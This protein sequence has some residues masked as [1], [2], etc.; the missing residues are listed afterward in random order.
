MSLNQVYY[1]SSTIGLE[2]GAGFRIHAATPGVPAD[3]LRQVEKL[4][5]YVPPR[6][7]PIDPTA[8]DLERFPLSLQFKALPGGIFVF[9]QAK[10]KGTDYSGRSGNYFVHLVT[11]SR[12]GQDV[13][14]KRNI[15]L[16][17][18]PVW[19]NS[20]IATT[21]L[22]ALDQVTPGHSVSPDHVDAFLRVAGGAE[23]LEAFLGAVL[24]ALRER[25]RILIVAEESDQVAGW[26]AVALYALPRSLA[27]PVSFNTYVSNPQN[28]DHLIVGAT[29]DCDFGFSPHEMQGQF[30]V[31]DFVG[32]RF[33]P[34]PVPSH[35]A[36]A[37]ARLVRDGLASVAEFGAFADSLPTPITLE[38]L[39]LAAQFFALRKTGSIAG[40]DP[41]PM[42]AWAEGRR[43]ALDAG[44]RDQLVTRVVDETVHD[45]DPK[46]IERL[47]QIIEND[48][49]SCERRWWP[50]AVTAV[51]ERTLVTCARE[52]PVERLDNWSRRLAKI[53]S[54]DAQDMQDRWW[55]GLRSVVDSPDRATV[56]LRLAN[57]AP[58]LGDH[59]ADLREVGARLIGPRLG[60]PDGDPSV[61]QVLS[62]SMRDQLLEGSLAAWRQQH[63]GVPGSELS[64]LLQD[65]ALRRVV[66]A[67]ALEAGD[68]DLLVPILVDETD[69][70]R[71]NT[72]RLEHVWGGLDEHQGRIPRTV[73]ARASLI[74]GVIRAIWTT[75]DPSL[76][77]LG[78]IAE[79]TGPGVF[80][81]CG[82]F[83]RVCDTAREKAGRGEPISA[84]LLGLLER[85][86][87]ILR[88]S[89]IAE[90][91][92]AASKMLETIRKD[93]PRLEWIRQNSHALT[94]CEP[95]PLRG[96]L[97]QEIVQAICQ[98]DAPGQVSCVRDLRG[99][100]GKEVV[101][102]Y[103][104]WAHD[105]LLKTKNPSFETIQKE[106]EAYR[107]FS[108]DRDG[109]AIG[110]RL[111]D[112]LRQ[113]R[114]RME[115][116]AAERVRKKLQNDPELQRAW[117]EIG[118]ASRRRQSFTALSS[119]TRSW[120]ALSPLSKA[121]WVVLVVGVGSFLIGL[122]MFGH[123][124]DPRI[125]P[126]P[127]SLPNAGL[128]PAWK[129]DTPS[130][131]AP[132]TPGLLEARDLEWRKLGALGY[133]DDWRDHWRT[134][135]L[136][137][138]RPGPPST[139]EPDAKASSTQADPSSGGAH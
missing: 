102:A 24:L 127:P 18:S 78:K 50:A 88:E 122:R 132:G 72:G 16:W 70:K 15:E 112:F 123:R 99:V 93:R 60:V 92:I 105:A 66:K 136:D 33:S 59:A 75:E 82:P 119:L 96:R 13:R 76:S 65:K 45:G 71:Q 108:A 69:P 8:E 73:A 64:W 120:A 12:P 49:R 86:P 29:A 56:F 34:P 113:T 43:L 3:V 68:L 19:A 63:P 61:R 41:G 52:A 42:L 6:N 104:S 46:S 115:P 30:S 109:E 138:N 58:W 121:A 2:G 130:T 126:T 48:T 31:F 83:R 7:A 38:E 21:E 124:E 37:V 27:D 54:L 28:T 111:L 81:K 101:D 97:L 87:L 106:L 133:G 90:S 94:G 20:E 114:K 91:L 39:D 129:T 36:S 35:Y 9:G 55:K 89:G 107:S 11:T 62:L 128:P 139:F 137:L 125:G 25:R 117:D 22:P 85:D 116:V 1:T 67:W 131:T 17:R 135:I 118:A 40:I 110:L 10:Y 103:L 80:A 32:G 77:E 26:V 14:C 4:C 47:L 5:V 51:A 57:D 84:G 74:D 100:L 53:V 44:T 79:T 23:H 95:G 98:G 134:S